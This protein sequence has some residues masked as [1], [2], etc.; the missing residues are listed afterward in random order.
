MIN[1]I[2]V[3]AL[4]ELFETGEPMVLVDCRESDEHEFCRISGAK[5]IPLSDF[6]NRATKDL[7]RD[8]QIFIHC[9][10]GGRSLRACEFLVSQG[11]QKVSNVTGGIDA[12]SVH[13]DPAV[14]RY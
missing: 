14:P 2:S 13:V 6:E 5:L 9:H 10:H 1:Q 11:Y 8:D 12:W 3:M 4:K 7:N